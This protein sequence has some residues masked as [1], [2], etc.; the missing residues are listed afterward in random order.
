MK[1][2]TFAVIGRPGWDRD[3]AV[4]KAKALRR[5][6]ADIVVTD[7]E[8]MDI[9][10]GMARQGVAEGRDV[11]DLVGRDVADYIRERGLY[12]C[13]MDEPAILERLQR[14]LTVHRYH[15][16]LGVADTAERLAARFGVDPHRARL[17]GLLHDCAK[18]LPYGEMVRLVKAEAPE[19]DEQ[20]LESEPVLHAPAG[21]ALAK[22]DFGV[23]DPAILQAIRRH[24]LGGPDMTAMDALIYVADFIEPGRKPFPGLKEVREAAE[25]DI[26]EAMRMSAKYSTDYLISRGKQPHPRTISIL[27]GGE[28]T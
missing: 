23:R 8:G 27:S 22:R 6:G 21:M 5:R 25:T 18:S 12:L 19:I 24:T 11:A 10:S 17:A 15:H 13:A 26:F 4:Q 28:A 14:T 2:T 16:T 3:A 9:S 20:E 7:I 1:L